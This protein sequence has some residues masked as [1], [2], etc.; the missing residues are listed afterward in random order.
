V[1][2]IPAVVPALT[3]L[4]AKQVGVC[5]VAALTQ[6]NTDLGNGNFAGTAN[7]EQVLAFGV[8]P[9]AFESFIVFDI[10]E[11]PTTHENMTVRARVH[12]NLLEGFVDPVD[13]ISAVNRQSFLILSGDF[14]NP[15]C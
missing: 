10:V 4:D 14:S 1:G 12:F 2:A 5:A 3:V 13:A 6:G 8:L 7:R 9:A 15:P 11:D